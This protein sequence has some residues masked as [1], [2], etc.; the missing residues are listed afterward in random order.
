M[1]STASGNLRQCIIANFQLMLKLQYPLIVV[2]QLLQHCADLFWGVWVSSTPCDLMVL[3]CAFLLVDCLQGDGSGPTRL[4]SYA[5]SRAEVHH[6]PE[7]I[8]NPL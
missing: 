5:T 8:M 4:A 1:T 3:L 6:L 2:K 7:N